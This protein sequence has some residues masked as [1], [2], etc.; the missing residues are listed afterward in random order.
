MEGSSVFRHFTKYDDP[1]P[2]LTITGF[3][4]IDKN[5][6]RNTADLDLHELSPNFYV[7]LQNKNIAYPKEKPAPTNFIPKMLS[8]IK[9]LKNANAQ[10]ML[11][12]VLMETTK[13]NSITLN[14]SKS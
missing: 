2:L 9:M 14:S 13:N 6:T 7:Q 5:Y 8:L 4:F 12:T 10:K 3:E 1:N 11:I